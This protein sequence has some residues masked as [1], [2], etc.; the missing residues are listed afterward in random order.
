M[1][2]QFHTVNS[3][4]GSQTLTLEALVANLDGRCGLVGE[5]DLAVVE[6][7]F[8]NRNIRQQNLGNCFGN[9]RNRSGSVRHG[10][11]V[12]ATALVQLAAVTCT[13]QTLQELAVGFIED[14]ELVVTLGF[15]TE[16][17]T[18]TNNGNLNA[19]GLATQV[20]VLAELDVDVLHVIAE[21]S[22]LLN[23]LAH[24]LFQAFGDL[25]IA[26]VDVDFHDHS[27]QV[28]GLYRVRLDPVRGFDSNAVPL[29]IF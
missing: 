16:D 24:V 18:S 7:C 22:E 23:L 20:T 12:L 14:R 26:A 29:S 3:F 25:D 15:G 13:A 28:G 6:C 4:C 2:D 9:H 5:G 8:F 11:G 10:D 19:D 21:L 17:R 27:L 1:A